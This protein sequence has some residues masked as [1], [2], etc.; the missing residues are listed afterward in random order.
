MHGAH[1][2]DVWAGGAAAVCAPRSR[3]SQWPGNHLSHD[4]IRGGE[5]A[6]PARVHG[7]RFVEGAEKAH[8]VMHS[9]LHGGRPDDVWAG[10]Q[11][12]EGEGLTIC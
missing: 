11:Q 1:P 2:D 12:L 5:D 10:G 6:M 9:R 3:A 4:L 8:A 7:K